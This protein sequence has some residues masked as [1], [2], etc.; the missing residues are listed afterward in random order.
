M[1][2][3]S[4]RPGH[5]AGFIPPFVDLQCRSQCSS[6]NGQ[7][8]KVPVALGSLQHFTDSLCPVVVPLHKGSSWISLSPRRAM[9]L[10]PYSS[11]VHRPGLGG[12][13]GDLEAELGEARPS[14]TKLP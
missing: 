11:L 8:S 5:L 9:E 12:G 3:Q 13:F 6:R 2:V 4:Q 1:A 7:G 14:F 10:L